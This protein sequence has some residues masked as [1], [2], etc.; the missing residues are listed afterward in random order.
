MEALVQMHAEEA[1]RLRDQAALL[2]NEL[3]AC[4]AEV[5]QLRAELD[6]RV[7]TMEGLQATLASIERHTAAQSKR[8]SLTGE[9]HCNSKVTNAV[10][11]ALSTV[12]TL[13]SIEIH[14]A[15]PVS[16]VF[17]ES[18]QDA[19]LRAAVLCRCCC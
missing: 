19:A 8:E 16:M 15:V 12:R 3:A 9:S 7:V 6:T 10:K 4:E 11:C 17:S 5:A 14:T 13:A 1:A 2:R 18:F